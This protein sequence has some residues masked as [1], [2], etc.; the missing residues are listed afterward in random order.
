MSETI[1]AR[2]KFD[3][4]LPIETERKFSPV[5]PE[6]L[7]FLKNHDTA[8]AIEQAYLSSPD[9]P[10]SL[11]L[12]EYTDKEGLLAYEATLKDRGDLSDEGLRRLEVTTPISPGL[13]E[14]Y[15]SAEVPKL[16]KIR[17]E[18]FPGVTVDF[19][20][21]GTVQVESEDHDQWQNY[22]EQ[23][24]SDFIDV[25]G[26]QQADN[27][28][29]AHVLHGGRNEEG[30]S[31]PRE[32][33]ATS[34]VEDILAD[35][36]PGALPKIVHIGGRSGS[37]KSTIVREVLS[38]LRSVGVSSALLSTDDYHRGTKWLTRYNNGEPWTH[39]DERIV[40]D[41]ENLQFDLQ[42]LL[43]GSPIKK[44]VIDWSTVEPCVESM[45]SPAEAIIIEGIY[46]TDPS[47]T[48]E[49]DLTY[50]LPTPLATCVGRRL[51]RDIRERPQFSDPA[52]S[53]LYMLEE[54]EPAYRRQHAG[55]TAK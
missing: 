11:R 55:G 51:L 22:K 27:E 28:H 24:G 38:E 48:N 46:A 52:L 16:K 35:R 25:T 40:Y 10:F 6:R 21:D 13:Y 36:K 29:K 41:L 42:K 32:L 31:L 1:D 26:L 49:D 34:I 17:S 37:G 44:R 12:R 39:W 18:P 45:Q 19:Y 8:T 30:F 15:T 9:E 50:I 20:E 7:S 2:N 14:Y 43:T 53:L 33:A 23:F 5:F 47:I 54:A 4:V 3:Y